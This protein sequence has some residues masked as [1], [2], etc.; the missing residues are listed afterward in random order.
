VEI[1]WNPTWEP[2]E[3]QNTC[4]SFKQSLNKFEEHI[5]APNLSQPAPN[6]HLNDIRKQGF[7]AIQEGDK[8]QPYNV[9]H[10]NKVS[11]DIQLINPQADIT[12]TGHCEYWIKTIDLIEYQETVTLFSPD[13]TMLPEVYTDTVACIYNVD[14]KCKGMLTPERLNILRKAFDRAKCSG[15]HDHIQPPPISFASEL[16]GFIARKD[17]SA[18]KH[19]NKK[20]KDSSARILPSHITAAFQKWALVTKEKMAPPL[21]PKFPHY[22]SEHPRDKVFGANTN[23]FSSRFSGIS[24]CHPIYHENT[25][26]LATRHAIYSAAVSTEETAIFMLLPSWNKDM[27]TNPYASLCQKYPRMCK[28]LGT[29]PLNKLQYA[30]VPFWNNKQLQFLNT[31]GNFR[32]LPY[33]TPRAGSASMLTTKTG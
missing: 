13:D 6:E 31:P 24:I 12:A 17:T 1:S 15:L 10:Q 23:A 16:V 20:T 21:D 4:E 14:G 32:S 30:K 7:S 28:F 27:T 9:D 26:L 33:G 3:L 18:S 5:A 22:W 19:T 2:E 11:F 29:I 8:Y 25:M